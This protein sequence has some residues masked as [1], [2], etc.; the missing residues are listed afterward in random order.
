MELKLSLLVAD[1]LM[2][3]NFPVR[4]FESTHKGTVWVDLYLKKP[5]Y[6]KSVSCPLLAIVDD[7]EPYVTML[8][9]RCRPQTFY[10]PAHPEFFTQMEEAINKAIKM[11]LDERGR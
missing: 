2:E 5:E 8:D 7:D 11:Y 1:W 9:D 10:N 4:T 6:P 3:K